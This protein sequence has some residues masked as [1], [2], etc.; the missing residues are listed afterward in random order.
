MK[1]IPRLSLVGVGYGDF[2]SLFNVQNEERDLGH[3]GT[4]EIAYLKR[5]HKLFRS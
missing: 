4:P 3:H 5:Y 2:V 1:A